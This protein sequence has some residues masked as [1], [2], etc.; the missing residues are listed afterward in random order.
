MGTLQGFSLVTPLVSIPISQYT[1]DKP[2]DKVWNYAGKW[3][4]VLATPG[5]TKIFRLDGT[6][7]TPVLTIASGTRY[8]A[9]C[10]LVDNLVH[11]LLFRSSTSYVVSVEYIPASGT[12]VRWSQ[13][14]SNTPVTFPSGA[15]TATLTVDGTGRMWLA[16]DG[17]SD[18]TVWWSD[19]PYTTFSSPITIATGVTDDD[20]CV[21]T[22]L[23]GK[24]G[25]FW[26]NQNTKKFGFRTH[27][28]GG[29][30]TTWSA[31]DVPASQ[32]A[33]NIGAGMSDDHMSVKM[34]SD[35]TLYFA[36]KTSYDLP[37]Y[38][39]ISLLIRRPDG[40]WDNLYPVTINQGTQP[41]IILNETQGTIKVVYTTIVNGGDIV[42]RESSMENI[43]FG[44]ER[45]LISGGGYLYN[46]TTSSHAT[47]NPEVVIMATNQSTTPMQAVS[48]LASD[49][50]AD[51][52]S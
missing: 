11:I 17:T 14:S 47:Y 16:S 28:E 27:N 49:S 37:G 20:L 44:V 45:T 6:S 13:R 1:K 3:W 50:P 18:I 9:D 48:I 33:L 2:Q 5:G 10:W 51:I 25:I 41:H 7:W 34:A 31:D 36:V 29:V 23:P 8:K 24:I 26:S 15:E 52:I 39:Q 43:L 12:Y 32:S 4:C 38:P 19:A 35:G 30:A 40:T 42:Y 21:L 22:T 46:Y